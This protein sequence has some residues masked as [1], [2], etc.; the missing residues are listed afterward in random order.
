MH[1][2]LIVSVPEQVI[3]K[4]DNDRKDVSRSKFVLRLFEKAYGEELEGDVK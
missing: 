3:Q 1:K 4:I 2:P